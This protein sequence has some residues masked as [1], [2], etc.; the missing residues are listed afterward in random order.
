[1]TMYEL[2]KL[3]FDICLFKRGPQD[4]PASYTLMKLLMVAYV[5]TS[6]LILYLSVNLLDAVLQALVE[7]VLIVSLSW[8][9]LFFSGR[10][11]R[12]LQT[13][14]ALIS[15]D[16]LISLFALPA[17]ATLVSQQ[18]GLAFFSM[19]A[20]MLWHGGVC[21]HIFCHALEKPFSFALAIALLYI[22]TSYIVIDTL[23]FSKT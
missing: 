22:L 17:M 14:N 19:I 4:M 8:L 9:I 16:A 11:T 12:F 5:V 3:T 18:S 1:M 10:P 13:T 2:L 21:A 20:L 23:F 15:T 7:V 6:I